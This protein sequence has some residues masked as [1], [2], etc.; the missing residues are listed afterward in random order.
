MCK[1]M[2]F[3]NWCVAATITAENANMAGWLGVGGYNVLGCAIEYSVTHFYSPDLR[4]T[5]LMCETGGTKITNTIPLMP[6]GLKSLMP[7]YASN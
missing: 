6:M 7:I 5:C 3:D 4:G 1:C 2:G